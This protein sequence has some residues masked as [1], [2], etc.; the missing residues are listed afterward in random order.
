MDGHG[1][2]LAAI[3][4]DSLLGAA[5]FLTNSRRPTS[6]SYLLLTILAGGWLLS[7]DGVLRSTNPKDA[8]FWIKMTSVWGALTLPTFGLLRTSI[9][10]YREGWTAHLRALRWWYLCGVVVGV[11]A[12]SPY[13]ILSVAMSGPFPE[14][15]YGWAGTVELIYVYGSLLAI[16][17]FL[18]RDQ[19]SP[20]VQGVHRIELQFVLLACLM[21]VISMIIPPVVARV[22]G[23]EA[24][25]YAPLR[26]IV[27]HLIIAY[28]IT[29][30]GILHVRAVFRLSLSYAFLGIYVALLFTATWTLARLVT[31]LS[32]DNFSLALCAGVVTALLVNAT[33]T[34]VRRIT[35]KILPPEIDLEQ[36]VTTVGRLVQQVTTLEQLIPQF[37]SVLS[38]AVG[39]PRVTVLLADDGNHSFVGH[40]ATA[41]T[42][43]I[44]SGDELHTWFDAGARELSLEELQRR[45]PS[46][47]RDRLLERMESLDSD[48]ILAIRY[49]DRISG[50]LIF[51]SRPS[52]KIYGASGRATLQLIADQLGVS[53][54]NSR[55]YTE[56]RQ[57]QAY[58]EFLVEHLTCGVIATNPGGD[59]TVVNPEARRLLGLDDLAPAA[60]LD[61]PDEIA[62]LIPP[63]L[64]G[65]F[66][67]RDEEI[68]LRP[69]ARD[70]VN[71]R[72]S[73]L[74][75]ASEVSR[76]LGAVLVLN[77]YSAIERLQR[78]IRQ[79][80]R[81]ASIGT[82]ASGMAHEIKNPLTAL[83]TF[84]QLL[85]KRYGDP[86][87]RSDFALLG[88][89][90][91]L[92]IERIVNDL[93]AFARPAPL[94][95]EQ[96]NLH[97]II[98]A[99]VRLVTPQAAKL[100]IEVRTALHA[101][102]DFVAA[103]RDRLQQ[104]LLNLILN[105]LQASEE[106]GW[107]ELRT[108]S[109]EGSVLMDPS[110][111][112]DV[113]DGGRGISKEMLPH[114]FDPFYTTKSEGTGLG[115][116]VSYN[117]IAE[118]KGRLEV[119]SESGEGTCFSI[120]LPVS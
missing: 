60:E 16:C 14:P 28:G 54:A 100:H 13:F 80:D 109:E 81:L 96:L 37:S 85:P 11:C 15:V 25:P 71:L 88:G 86:E 83:K 22:T 9:V 87:F 20:R 61:L 104:V 57:S 90:E 2:A 41:G 68:I 30:R 5:V 36:I 35:K 43:T 103:D 65:D 110:I 51:T 52:G 45:P 46:S 6:R 84:T 3:V 23:R 21:I 95:I 73:C 117:I 74:P 77:D 111:R 42:V 38:K 66:V 108:E 17:V 98:T 113:R 118:H 107:V 18:V 106:G 39:A 27:F 64:D 116:S 32:G 99:A 55:L 50:I 26:A 12:F 8:A 119:A 120:Y 114:I 75:F 48:L 70:E 44:K 53:I 56:A 63:T 7:F 24:I 62:R 78:Q 34:P 59:L 115:L 101:R 82:L 1:F 91:I 19:V 10:E 93:L 79:A 97:D 89:N 67:G 105:A 112:L 58:S 31:G 40:N 69:G 4:I 92:R 47:E 49:H 33:G 72:V 102:T 29:S 94:M 76:L